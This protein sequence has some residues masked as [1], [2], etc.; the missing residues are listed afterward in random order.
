[1]KNKYFNPCPHCLCDEYH[2]KQIKR[3]YLEFFRDFL[4]NKKLAVIKNIK[5]KKI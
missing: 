5:I 3:I 1:M 4:K 2:A